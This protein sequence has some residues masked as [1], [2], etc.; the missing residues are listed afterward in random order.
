[1]RFSTL[2]MMLGKAACNNVEAVNMD[3]LTVDPSTSNLLDPS[4][5]GSGIV[6]RLDHLLET[7][8]EEDEVKE[9]RLDKLASFQPMMIKRA[10]KCD[11]GMLKWT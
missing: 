9:E 10:M 4:C 7:E 2:K 11:T 5:S 6:N 8:N 3:F 1:M